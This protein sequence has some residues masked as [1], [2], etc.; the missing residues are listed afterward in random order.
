MDLGAFL[1]RYNYVLG[2]IPCVYFRID[3]SPVLRVSKNRYR[4]TKPFVRSNRLVWKKQTC[5]IVILFP[6][7]DI[8]LLLSINRRRIRTP[9]RC[10]PAYR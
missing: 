4:N 1:D 2:F 7:N 3:P 9:I 10:F 8:R 6:L 5:K